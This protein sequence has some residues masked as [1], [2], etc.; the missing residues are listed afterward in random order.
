[1]MHPRSGVGDPDVTHLDLARERQSRDLR[2]RRLLRNL[3]L[4]HELAHRYAA[5]RGGH[6]AELVGVGNVGLVKALSSYD[7]SVGGEFASH[8]E[9]IVVAEIEDYLGSDR[10]GLKGMRHTLAR[11]SKV[12]AA[13]KEI[14]AAMSRQDH[15]QE[16]AKSLQVRVDVLVEG[17]LGAV[18]RDGALLTDP[19]LR[20]AA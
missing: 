13:R 20:G 1:M 15:V 19:N 18:E 10:M 16:F 8:A 5:D 4:V 17:L 3:P 6:A 12:V 2:D 7:A 9:P 11:D 14:A